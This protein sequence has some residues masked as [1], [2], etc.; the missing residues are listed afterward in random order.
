MPNLLTQ[1]R[2]FCPFRPDSIPGLQAWYDAADAGTISVATGVSQWRDKS[3]FARN[4]T[5]GTAGLQPAYSPAN[6]IK[7]VACPK[8]SGVVN[9]GLATASFSLNFNTTSFAVFAIDAEGV[10]HAVLDGN[11]TLSRTK[12]GV[13]A[14]NKPFLY[15]GTNLTSSEVISVGAPT[16][17]SGVFA[18]VSSLI[19]VNRRS[20]DAGTSGTYR[21]TL[22][23]RLGYQADTVGRLNGVIGEVLVYSGVLAIDQIVA[24]E[25]YLSVKWGTP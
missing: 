15:S 9:V 11:S 16:V 13:N 24:I 22:G 4:A 7:G 14:A 2:I 23:I 20:S 8:Y 6:R 17:V 3:E 21:N 18:G 5:Q 19:R 10:E 1:R 25:N 12:I